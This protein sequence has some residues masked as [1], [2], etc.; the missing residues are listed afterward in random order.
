MGMR[1]RI[2]SAVVAFLM[3]L[4]FLLAITTLCSAQSTPSFQSVSGEFARQWID[5]LRAQNSQPVHEGKGNT[6]GNGT[7]LWNWGSA[8][9]GSKIENGKLLTDPNYLRPQLNLSGNWLG[10]TYTDPDTGMPVQINLDPFTG[11]RTYTY[12]NPSTGQP[13]FSYYTYLDAKTGKTVYAYTDPMTGNSVY[14]GEAPIDL[15]N[16]LSN[17]IVQQ[18]DTNQNDPWTRL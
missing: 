12:L 1:I 11:K 14:S 18:T 5:S 2:V 16:E 17:R 7:D 6:N 9:K 15:V 3:I 10:D 13:V 8:P 4:C